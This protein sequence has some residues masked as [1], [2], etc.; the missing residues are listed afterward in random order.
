LRALVP[1]VSVEKMAGPMA[2]PRNPSPTRKESVRTDLKRLAGYNIT[3]DHGTPYL[4][5]LD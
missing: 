4:S 1:T 5:A 3:F 2:T